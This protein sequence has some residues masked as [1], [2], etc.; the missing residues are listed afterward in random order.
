MRIGL[1]APPWVP[2]P[3]PSYGGTEAVIDQL[4]LGLQAAGHD[5]VLC[6]TGD[7][8]CAVPTTW[9]FEQAQT[10][11]IGSS[12]LELRQV[13]H[14]YR[15]LGD[16]DIVH[17][18]TLAGAVRAA[19]AGTLPVVT[20]NHGPFDENLTPIFRAIAGRIPI[21]AISRRQAR[22]AEG[23]PI[24]AVIHHGIDPASFPVGL[25][26]GG[27]VAF[28]GRMSSCKGVDI[29]ARAARAAGVPLLI[30]AKMREPDEV[31]YFDRAVRP[32]LGHDVEYLGELGAVDKLELLCGA[33]ALVN[34]VRW[35]EPFGM[36]MIEALACGTPVIASP[37]GSAPE[38]VD[39]GRTGFLAATPSALVSA[40][41]LT[42]SLDRLAC[43]QSVEQHFSTE[44]M[45]ADHLALYHRVLGERPVQSE[46]GWSARPAAAR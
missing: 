15:H 30:A 38:I 25:G 28:V 2:V 29:A 11:Q 6:A 17:D 45:V 41:Q 35:H 9:T 10:N 27:Y 40:L 26:D 19:A 39:A 13:L 5:V 36:V 32:L 16:V 21:V 44:R 22:S 42:D 14:A 43:R 12:M 37:H 7:S 24:A 34:P 3:P 20:T 18:H 23:I 31:A 1:I 4:A 8:R 33:R 46:A